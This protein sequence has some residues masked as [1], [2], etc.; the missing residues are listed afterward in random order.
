[1][2]IVRNAPAL[3]VSCRHTQMRLRR[4]SFG[5][6]QYTAPLGAISAHVRGFLGEGLRIAIR[7]PISMACSTVVC[8]KLQLSNYHS[9]AILKHIFDSTRFSI[10]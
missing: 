3:V 4:K 8:L 5:G 7:V 9:K 6:V 1:M 10:H 2:M